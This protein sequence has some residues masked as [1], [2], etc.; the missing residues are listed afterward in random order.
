MT[1]LSVPAQGRPVS[2]SPAGT[3]AVPDDPIVPF[4]E[5]AWPRSV[6]KASMTDAGV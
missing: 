1:I 5:G 3:L 6:L 2:M 4:I